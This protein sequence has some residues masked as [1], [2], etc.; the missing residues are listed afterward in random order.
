MFHVLK[1]NGERELYSVDKVNESI[2]RAGIPTDLHTSVLRHITNR[3][4]DNIPT[5]EIYFHIVEFLKS[6]HLPY[7]KSRYSLKQ[8]IMELGPTGY[9]FEDYVGKILQH[10][11]FSITTRQLLRGK[12]IMHEIDVIA[13]KN[14][15]L[16]N[17]IMVEAKYHN[18]VGLRTNVHV[19]MYTKSRFE[20]IKDLYKF[21]DVWVVTNT[22]ATVDAIAYAECVGIK[23]ITWGHPVGG[24][25]RNLIE[26]YRLY[27]VTSLM[28]LNNQ[29]KQ[30]LLQN[31]IVLCKDVCEDPSLI[32]FLNLNNTKLAQ[33]QEEIK[34]ICNVS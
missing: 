30:L 34:F 32:D 20:D 23:I 31:G 17:K 2:I 16:A 21:S 3:I 13:Q 7:A 27:P 19:P 14:T 22:K 24:S 33:V 26:K 18:A 4:Y 10:Q 28:T 6:S 25:L 5:S 12:C 8:A 9:P 1:A 11:G 29:Q 15:V